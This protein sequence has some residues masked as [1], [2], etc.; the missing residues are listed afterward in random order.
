MISKLGR[1][2]GKSIGNQLVQSHM[3]AFPGR[4]EWCKQKGLEALTTSRDTVNNEIHETCHS[5]S[6]Y[7]IAKN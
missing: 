1:A 7:F 5:I 4:S 3:S 6:T 2:L